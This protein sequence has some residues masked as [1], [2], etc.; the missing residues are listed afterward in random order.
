MNRRVPFPIAWRPPS[1]L[2]TAALLFAT[3]LFAQTVYT[4]GPNASGTPAGGTGSWS[5]TVADWTSNSGSTYQNWPASAFPDSAVFAGT[6]GTVTLTS[7]VTA[8]SVTFNT[9]GYTLTG[10][11]RTLTLD[12][13]LGFPAEILVPTA[14]HTATINV[15]LA[16]VDDKSLTFRGPGSVVLGGASTFGTSANIISGASVR[17][18]TATGSFNPNISLTLGF[19]VAGATTG[20][21]F[22]VDNTGA[23]ADTAQSFSGFSV[24]SGDSNVEAHNGA[25][26]QHLALELGTYDFSR[27]T[28]ATVNFAVSGGTNGGDTKILFSNQSPGFLDASAFFGGDNFAWLDDGLFIRGI[29]YASDPGA[30]SSGGAAS[31]NGQTYVRTTGAV[32]AQTTDTFATLNLA[33]AENF[34]IADGNT[35]TVGGILKSGGSA[36]SL[37]GGSIQA[38]TNS[39]P[40]GKVD[41]VVRT[42]LATDQLTIGA[43]I[44]DNGGTALVKSGA[45]T[46]KLTG[47]NTFAGFDYGY[48]YAPIGLFLN[49]GKL[50]IDT[51]PAANEPNP[52]GGGVLQFTGGTLSYTGSSDATTTHTFA[53]AGGS[54]TFEIPDASRTVTVNSGFSGPNTS[55]RT[56]GLIKSGAGRLV[57]GGTTDNIGLTLIASAGVLELAKASAAD[58]HAASTLFVDSGGT[59]RLAG[60]GDDQIYD[61]SDVTVDGLLDFNGRNETFG[62]LAGSGTVANNSAASHSMMTVGATDTSSL[63]SGALTDGSGGKK[64]SLAKTGLGT[65]TLTGAS[66]FS[67]GTT[68]ALGTIK[69]GSNTALGSGPITLAGGRIQGDGTAHTLDNALSLTADSRITGSSA[70]T[71]TDFLTNNDD[72]SLT[73]SNTGGTTFGGVKLTDAAAA[74]TLTLKGSGSTTITGAVLDNVALGGTFYKTGSGTL[75]LTGTGTSVTTFNVDQGALV[76]QGGA[77]GTATAMNLSGGST[78]TITGGTTG[79]ATTGTGGGLYAEGS[80]TTLTVGGGAHLTTNSA[81]FDYSSVVTITGSTTNWT[82]SD[83]LTLYTT[84]VGVNNSATASLGDVGLATFFSDNVAALTID[85]GGQVT[86]NSLAIGG[87]DG[88]AA[89]VTVGTGGSLTVGSGGSGTP[90]V[91]H[92]STLRIGTGAAA[93]TVSLAGV[94]LTGGGT[95]AFNH[96]DPITFSKAITG[97]SGMLTK[98]GSGTLIL[99]GANTYTGLT[100][101][102]GGTL[103]VGNGTSGSISNAGGVSLANGANLAFNRTSNVT[104]S[105]NID[106][107][108]NLLKAGS[109]TLTLSGTNTFTGSVSVTGGSVSISSD[110]KLGAAPTS[111]T[112]GA[113]TLNGGALVNSSNLTLNANRGVALGASGGTFSPNTST[114]LTYG[115]II[116]GSG[117]LTKSGSGTVTLSGANTYQGGT[118]ISTGT[119]NLSGASATLG[120]STGS[121]AANGGT[122]DLG[123]ASRTVGAVTIAGGTIQN[124]TLNGSAYD[125]QSGTVSAVLGGAGVALTKT[126]SGSLA[127]SGNNSFGGGL[128][129][130]AGTVSGTSSANAFGTGTV[131]LGDATGSNA[132]TLRVGT[133]GLTIANP[134]ALASGGTGTLT[135]GNTGTAISTTFSGGVTGTN[136]LTLNSNASSGTI[137]LSTNTVNNS[138]TVTNT[139]SGTGTTTIS[140]AVGGNV[141]GLIANST[142][143]AFTITGALTTN[144]SGTT[145]TNSAGTK[146]LTVSGG[147]GGSGSLTLKN[148]SATAAGVTLSGTAVNPSGTITNSGTG[149]GSASITA[150]VG[151]NVP[152]ITEASTTSA[153]NLSGALTVNSGGTTLTNG[154]ASGSALFTVSGGVGGTGNLLLRNNSAIVGGVTLSG[155]SV[156]PTGTVTNAGTGSGGV[157]VSAVVGANVSGITQNS[158][159][160]ALTLSGNNTFTGATTISA[161]LLSAGHAG[162]LGTTA[163]GTTVASG[164]ALEINAVAIGAEP[165]TLNGSGLS[166][167]G[168]LLGTGTSSLAGAV[169]LATNAS[170]G[171]TGAL[172]LS[173]GIGDGGNAR[174][175]TK[176]GTGTLTVAGT[177]TYTGGT[178]ISAGT[179]TLTGALASGP[180]AVSGTLRLNNAAQTTVSSLSGSG[181]INFVT[182]AT[183]STL[184]VNSTGN[185]LFAGSITGAGGFK[186]GGSGTLTVSGTGNTFTGGS[187]IDEGTLLVTNA[188]GSGLG[189]DAVTVKSGATLGGTGRIAASTTLQSGAHLAPGTSP[190]T[191][192]FT[193]GLSLL[194]GSALDFEL[195]T[196]SDKIVVSGG[197]LSGPASGTITLNLANSGGFAAGTTYTLFS[198]GGASLANFNFGAFSLGTTMP[199]FDYH[200]ALNG[201][202]NALELTA[203]VSAIPEPSLFAALAG[204]GVLAFAWRRRRAR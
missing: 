112:P 148:N 39:L 196:T 98:S 57:L 16:S 200:L 198:Y 150:G 161:G 119:L 176:V 156:N 186:K 87:T 152:A 153:L 58:V 104:Y 191:I 60:T 11:G 17:L 122:L 99:S 117:G 30:F 4:W 171:G 3:P 9:S 23:A 7:D 86:V 140:A 8:F 139:G 107:T 96:S 167:A 158:A 37:L 160:S 10:S 180:M 197:T 193:N 70:L 59:V 6:S 114:T 183:A 44:L 121:V 61:H 12:N 20:G 163:G 189:S 69:V 72:L 74:H 177:N 62:A 168:A 172:T 126:T 73:V 185:D 1:W 164:G 93:G 157:T 36:A 113:L 95:V 33:S 101:V 127:L 120:N 46:L 84:S 54:S 169:T 18:M 138:G 162:A 136:N 145:L 35:L 2:A 125:A 109:G 51:L 47:A 135:L 124:G 91:D 194:A 202:T 146:L 55:F 155:T 192:T 188:S 132:A 179:F 142:T 133:T 42:D 81:A 118:T 199:G 137:T 130:K 49:A 97:T 149:S 151:S 88:G 50:S 27:S 141:T 123:N 116:A 83:Y 15:P 106:G 21:T 201:T 79:W 56:D 25:T 63:F 129:L 182:G 166:S 14:G 195:G 66:T 41:L 71:F 53:A 80:G 170:I 134:I 32:T 65:L 64:L 115:G 5:T 184:F 92:N 147:V 128:A 34:T 22:I 13:P 131:T 67:G 108:G 154:N 102:D 110:A 19:T 175:L 45:G 159:T 82:N 165:L 190:G 78:T 48:G 26:G 31:I 24:A 105:G 29:N 111:A 173:G 52:L 76:I 40:L 204:S 85:G 174:V 38:P 203:T 178:T 89:T 28:G 94:N 103:Q 68:I 75:T 77:N 187:T 144:A 90:T 181:A 43:T 100:T 143:S